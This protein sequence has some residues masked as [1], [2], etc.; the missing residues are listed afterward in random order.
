MDDTQPAFVP[1]FRRKFALLP[2]LDA[3]QGF[4]YPSTKSRSSLRLIGDICCARYTPAHARSRHVQSG[5]AP[6]GCGR[7][8][9]ILVRPAWKDENRRG[10]VKEGPK[11]RSASD[12]L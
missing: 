1:A 4:Y 6:V 11:P 12:E 9:D 7:L 10:G 8:H 2:A 3:T 5:H